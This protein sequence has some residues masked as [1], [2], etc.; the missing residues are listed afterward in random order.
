MSR[1]VSAL[2][3]IGSAIL[4]SRGKEMGFVRKTMGIKSLT[5][6][7]KIAKLPTPFHKDTEK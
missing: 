5:T 6:H 1:I 3:K 7:L 4:G 2:K